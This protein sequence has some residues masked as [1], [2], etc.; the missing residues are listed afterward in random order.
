MTAPDRSASRLPGRLAALVGGSLAA[1]LVGA[2]VLD[3]PG[4]ERDAPES[5]LPWATGEG[6]GSVAS[7]QAPDGPYRF[8]PPPIEAVPLR[9]ELAREDIGVF[10]DGG[11][12]V[13]PN[14]FFELHPRSYYR[15]LPGLERTIPFPDHPEGEFVLRTNDHGFRND[16]DVSPVPP[17]HRV[18]VIGDSHTDG[19]CS[20]AEGF[21]HLLERALEARCAGTVEVLNASVSAYAFYNY[22]GVL[23]S[24]LELE[25][26]VVVL[27]VYAGNDFLSLVRQALH[28]M[29]REV[30]PDPAYRDRYAR[31]LSE[32]PPRSKSLLNQALAQ[33]SRFA[34]SP[35]V[36][37]FA[38]AVAC[39]L[40]REIARVCEAHGIE[41]VVVTIPSIW[42]FE[43]EPEL[44]S[45]AAEV[46]EL[47]PQWR[48]GNFMG[49]C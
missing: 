31:F 2:L 21:P 40:T 7:A 13:G 49:R 32:A 14:A 3:L 46:F 8:D 25:P 4:R 38:F 5:D 9:G 34:K 12:F 11:G 47:P 41:L 19:L 26:D 17:D 42:E 45:F 33:A 22:L 35:E 44:A 1:L 48:A 39:E 30:P 36:A 10:R 37:D 28:F 29:G 16:E 20:N 23:D 15:Y 24:W 6:S 43:L 27:S 18:L